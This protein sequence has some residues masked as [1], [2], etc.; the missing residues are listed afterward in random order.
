MCI[1]VDVN[2]LPA[3]LKEKHSAHAEFKPVFDWILKGKGKLVYGGSKYIQELGRL[4][5]CLAVVITLEKQNRT[6][7][8][9]DQE[10][11]D[12]QSEIDKSFFHPQFNDSHL[13]AI[14]IVSRCRLLCS[15]DKNSF[16]FI[17]RNQFYAGKSPAVKKPKI[18]SNPKHKGLL[19]GKNI[20][21]ICKSCKKAIESPKGRN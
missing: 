14:I 11:N 13:V 15:L 21:D 20:A 6:V 16:P 9:P 12:E 8:V 5:R 19:I 1:V 17:K 3:V 2:C 10:V 4:T 7:H 18:Y